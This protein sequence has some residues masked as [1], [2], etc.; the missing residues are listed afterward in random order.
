VDTTW[1]LS[2]DQVAQTAPAGVE[3]LRLCVF[4]A[5]ETIPL[6]LV[7]AEPGL[8]PRS[9]AA[10]VA[11]DDQAGVEEAAGACYRYSLVDRDLAG[12]RVHRLVQPV[13]RAQLAEP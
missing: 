10:A 11:T 7:T 13:V 4:L 9:L 8:L 12:I 5:S 2:I 1:Q 3:L 6:D